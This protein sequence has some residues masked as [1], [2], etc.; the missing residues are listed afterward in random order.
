MRRRIKW[1]KLAGAQ[2]YYPTTKKGRGTPRAPLP[3]FSISL[4]ALRPWERRSFLFCICNEADG[5]PDAPIVFARAHYGRIEAH[6]VRAGFGPG[7]T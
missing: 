5:T 1:H 7:S 3:V 2:I 6:V 4:Q